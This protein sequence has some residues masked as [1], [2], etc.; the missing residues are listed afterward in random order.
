MT[1][2]TWDFVPN[3]TV[4][5]ITAAGVKSGVVNR[6]E[7]VSTG[8]GTTITYYIKLAGDSVET[9]FLEADVFATCQAAS[10]YQTVLY[11]GGIASGSIA[12]TDSGSPLTVLTA[13]VTIDTVNVIPLSISGASLTFQSVV[14]TLNSQVGT[15]GTVA[16]V[17]GNIRITSASTGTSSSVSITD[18]NLFSSLAG[19][20]VVDDAVAGKANGAVEAYAA[21]IC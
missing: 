14:N 21:Q 2:V 7:A 19:F 9:A 10:A 17:G 18:T 11:G 3:Q 12:W 15:Y 4:W 8:A 16:I 6:A 13:S 20:S 1:T 5:V